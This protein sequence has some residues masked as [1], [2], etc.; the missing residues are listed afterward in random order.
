MVVVTE[1]HGNLN[2][3]SKNACNQA[4]VH[5]GEVGVVRAD[6]ASLT[7]GPCVC[8]RKCTSAHPRDR[9]LGPACQRDDACRLVLLR[10]LVCGLRLPEARS[11]R[12]G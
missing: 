12:R 3:R 8:E 2:N 10:W 7:E 5:G 9:A 11:S 1:T 6:T 4:D